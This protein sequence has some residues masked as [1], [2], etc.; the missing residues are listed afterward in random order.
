M[1]ILSVSSEIHP[2]VKTGGLADVAGALPLALGGLG[3]ECRTIVPGYPAVTEKLGKVKPV[4]SWSDL[5]GGAAKLHALNHA[6]LDL[7][8]LDA[9]HLYLRKGGPYSDNMGKDWPDNWRRFAALSRAAADVAAGKLPDWKPDIVHAH[10]WQAALTPAYLA[11]GPAAAVPSVMTVHNLAFQGQFAA[12]VFAELGLPDKAW[13]VE[14]VEYYGGVGFLKAGLQLASAITTVSPTYAQEIRSGEF[15]MGLDGLINARSGVVHGIVNGID[16][17]EW[18]PETDSRL[19]STYNARKLS[20]RS[21]NREA[22]EQR[23][24]LGSD[25][26]PIFCVISRLTWQK[27]MDVLAAAVDGIVS[28]GARL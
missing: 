15:G 23:F 8:V 21:A 17:S 24:Q 7:L 19:A 6:G 13:S 28:S 1:R 10:D 12:A 16:M 25:A 5:F 26:S 14:G 3:V 20:A 9:P 4:G 27:G 22:L 18:N 11:Y 2:L